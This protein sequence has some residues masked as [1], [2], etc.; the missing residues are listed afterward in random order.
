M[1]SSSNNIKSKSQPTFKNTRFYR[2]Y[3]ILFAKVETNLVWAFES[4]KVDQHV[5]DVRVVHSLPKNTHTRTT[6][7]GVRLPATI[8]F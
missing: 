7:G 6:V 5:S 1:S 3:Y 8:G 4:L 2:Y